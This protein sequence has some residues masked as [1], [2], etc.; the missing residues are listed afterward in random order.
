[1]PVDWGLA[2]R[3]GGV[4]FGLVFGVLIVL[5]LVMWLTGLVIRRTSVGSEE[6]GEKKEGD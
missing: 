1:M 5:A 3:I 6:A 4:G 2:A